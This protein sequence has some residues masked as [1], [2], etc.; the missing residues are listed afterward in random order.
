MESVEIQKAISLDASTL[1]SISV[2]AKKHWNYPEEWMKAWSSELKVTPKYIAANSV[3]KLLKGDEI[4]GFCSIKKDHNVYEVDH[5]WILP[6]Y[7]GHGYGKQ[8]LTTALNSRCPSGSRIRVY[9]DPNS[10]EFY[11]K[12]G[13][14]LT[15]YFESYPKGRKLP[16]LEK[17]I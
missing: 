9:A 3:Y 4:I 12:L 6:E 17:T 5:L 2:S 8:L 14:T 7:M 15:D 13:F 10:K 16:V 1:S 11:E